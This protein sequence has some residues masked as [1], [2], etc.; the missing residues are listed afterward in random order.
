M[1]HAFGA[2]GVRVN[3]YEDMRKAIKDAKGES[4]P[5]IIEVP[6]GTGLPSTNRFKA[7]PKIR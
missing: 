1:A 7:L 2:N 6:I 3:N 4:L 5:T